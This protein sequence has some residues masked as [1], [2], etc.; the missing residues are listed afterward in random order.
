M[1]VTLQIDIGFG[2]VI[3]P[4]AAEIE[5]PVLLEFAA[6]GGGNPATP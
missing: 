1:R 6:Q 3:V 4:H 5:Y 2:D